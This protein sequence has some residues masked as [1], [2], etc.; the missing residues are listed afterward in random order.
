MEQVD[1]LLRRIDEAAQHFLWKTWR[2]VRNAAC[3][4][5]CRQ[6]ALLGRAAT[7]AQLVV[8]TARRAWG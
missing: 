2:S 5:C 1:D 3:D 7:E 4:L 8:Q 6:P